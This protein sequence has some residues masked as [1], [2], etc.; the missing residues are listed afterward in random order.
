MFK[1]HLNPLYRYAVAGVLA[2][3]LHYVILFSLHKGLNANLVLATSV[4]AFAGAVL[5]Y[6]INYFYT[7]NSQRGHF[8]A[9]SSFILIAC[10]GL[11][12]NAMVVS[13]AFY[14]LALSAISAQISATAVTFVWNY[15]ANRRW[16]Y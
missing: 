4:G 2:T 13:L 14:L 7:F 1:H 11:A 15:Q 9:S 5:N 10:T 6:F 12:L 16:T 3:L 8:L